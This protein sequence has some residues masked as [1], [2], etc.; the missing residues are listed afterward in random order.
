[1]F[2]TVSGTAAVAVL[3]AAVSR[4]TAV[5]LVTLAVCVKTV[6][7]VLVGGRRERD[8]RAIVLCRTKVVDRFVGVGSIVELAVAL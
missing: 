3:I 1:M 2:V 4:A 8:V 7:G 6:A 5:A